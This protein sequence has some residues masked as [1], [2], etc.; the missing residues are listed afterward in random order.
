MFDSRN[1]DHPPIRVGYVVKRYPRYSET[2]IVNEV[3]AHE[4][5][6]LPIEIFSIRPPVDTHFQDLISQ[7][8]APVNYLATGVSKASELWKTI[9]D[10][11][12][13][14][15]VIESNLGLLLRH[16]PSDVVSAVELADQALRSGI[17][18]FHAHFATSAA[19]VAWI[20]S[21]LTG[22]PFTL[23]AHAKDIFHEDV[24]RAQLAAKINASKATVTVSDFN[25]RFLSPLLNDSADRVRRIYN[26]LNLRHF[27]YESPRDRA[28]TI[29][30][31]GRLVEKKGFKVLI[32]ACARLVDRKLAF[33]ALIIGDGPL[34]KTLRDQTERLGIDSFVQ[35]LGP[36][37]QDVVKTALHDAA[38]FAAPCVEGADGNRDGLPTVLLESM[39][40]GTPCVSTPVTGIP[41]AVI[42]GETGLIVPQHDAV[43]LAD[44]MQKLLF[45]GDARETLARAARQHIELNFDIQR[46]TAIQRQLFQSATTESEPTMDRLV[47]AAMVV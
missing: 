39:A 44:A 26:G 19:D 35:F 37:P 17:T 47:E 46:S 31:V 3:L 2:F 34:A 38:V 13:R 12:R 43:A 5:A 40:L 10:A 8:R 11:T 16:D 15:P 4:A 25:V 32:D 6:G 9:A 27:R 21:Q 41:E 20:A 24:D 36:Q 14:H 45:D 7:V 23:T 42:D 28:P 1:H 30:A 22:I 29:L 33:Q 18:H